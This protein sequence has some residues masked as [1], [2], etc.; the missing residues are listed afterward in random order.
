MQ[1]ERVFSYLFGGNIFLFIYFL[2]TGSTDVVLHSLIF[3]T[4]IATILLFALNKETFENNV[5]FAGIVFLLA[6]TFVSSIYVPFGGSIF[7]WLIIVLYN[8]AQSRTMRIV[9]I[10]KVS[11][12]NIVINTILLVLNIAYEV[13]K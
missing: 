2:A 10:Q 12:R 7:R 8:I 6:V 3:S 11:T 13:V 4:G 9:D 1:G 5:A